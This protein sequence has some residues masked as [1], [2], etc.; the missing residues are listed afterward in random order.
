MWHRHTMKYYVTSKM[1]I[2]TFTTKR[3]A[4]EDMVLEKYSGHKRTNML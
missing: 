1:S 3:T 4:L 2:L